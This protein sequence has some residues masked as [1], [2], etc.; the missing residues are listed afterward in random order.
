MKHLNFYDLKQIYIELT[1]YQLTNKAVK[2]NKF[3]E[4]E[5]LEILRYKLLDEMEYI[6]KIAKD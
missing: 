5:T 4:R 3:K 6:K 1:M 2:R